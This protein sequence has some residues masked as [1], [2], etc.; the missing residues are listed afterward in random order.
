MGK[1]KHAPPDAPKKRHGSVESAREM[2][3]LLTVRANEGH[4]EAAASIRGIA[5]DDA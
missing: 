2:V 1:K 3:K 5:D 4:P